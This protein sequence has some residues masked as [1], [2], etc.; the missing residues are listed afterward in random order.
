MPSYNVLRFRLLCAE[1]RMWN[2]LEEWIETSPAPLAVAWRI[3][4]F[5]R[6]QT[7]A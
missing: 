4:R 6:G 2:R 5:K 3:E 1:L 7:Q